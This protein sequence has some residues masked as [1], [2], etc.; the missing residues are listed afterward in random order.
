MEKINKKKF[1][2]AVN[3]YN[4]DDVTEYIRGLSKMITEA[5]WDSKEEIESLKN[6]K[7]FAL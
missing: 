5:E 4:K 3:G 6:E 2:T 1:R 7:T